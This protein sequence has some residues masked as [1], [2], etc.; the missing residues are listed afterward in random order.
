MSNRIDSDK[1]IFL[2]CDIQDG[3]G[4]SSKMFYKYN[5]MAHNAKRLTQVA[6][7]MN[8][9]VIATRQNL[10]L[11]GDCDPQIKRIENRVVFDKTKF[12]M[13]EPKVL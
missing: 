11:F 13:I 8:I 5:V 9:P 2:E 10:K 3:G 4:N 1:A 6:E 12:S 7:I